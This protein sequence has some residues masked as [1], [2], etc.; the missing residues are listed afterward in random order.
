MSQLSHVVNHNIKAEC[1]AYLRTYQK[2]PV[3]SK[4]ILLKQ[5][6]YNARIHKSHNQK[7]LKHQN[8]LHPSIDLFLI[9]SQQF[10][11]FFRNKID[12]SDDTWYSK[13]N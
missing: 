6:Q 11:N 10:Q 5:Y 1:Q 12:E 2:V 9:F 4:S 7:I 8:L 13:L 3:I